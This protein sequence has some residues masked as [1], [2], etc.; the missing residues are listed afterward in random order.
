MAF[1]T[2]AGLDL[3]I[4]LTLSL[5]PQRLQIRFV[6]G[7]PL[8]PLFFAPSSRA[9]TAFPNQAL[10]TSILWSSRK[11]PGHLIIDGPVVLDFF[12]TGRRKFRNSSGSSTVKVYAES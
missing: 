10:A 1:G 7:H 5:P 12:I 4:A 11:T 9:S 8:E 2:L 3:T 6:Q